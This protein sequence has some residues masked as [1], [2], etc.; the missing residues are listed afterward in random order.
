MSAQAT[1]LP[2]VA[3]A[4]P[5]LWADTILNTSDES[6]GLQL[7][8]A[9]TRPRRSTT[10]SAMSLVAGDFIEAND[11]SG[12]M[13]GKRLADSL[14]LK[15]GENVSLTVINADGQPEEAALCHSRAL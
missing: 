2:E 4:A 7:S 9:S 1:A 10:R 14:G 12:V 13:M 3:T 11:R 8:T 15:L 6:V 5:V